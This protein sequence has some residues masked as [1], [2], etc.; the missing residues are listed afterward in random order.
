MLFL[1]KL[2]GNISS[3]PKFSRTP[4]LRTAGIM[5]PWSRAYWT[6]DEV[7]ALPPPTCACVS[8]PRLSLLELSPGTRPRGDSAT[9]PHPRGPARLCCRLSPPQSGPRLAAGRDSWQLQPYDL[10]LC[11]PRFVCVFSRLLTSCDDPG[12]MYKERYP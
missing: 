12:R 10:G 9:T 2:L 5:H 4:R 3:F 11:Q 8:S 7:N 6:L 1:F